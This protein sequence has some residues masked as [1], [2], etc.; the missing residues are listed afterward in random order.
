M[1]TAGGPHARAASQVPDAR[2]VALLAVVTTYRRPGPLEG[3]LRSLVQ[4]SRTPD[5]I[6][7]MDND[8]AESVRLL[9]DRVAAETGANIVYRPLVENLGP[10]GAL[11]RAVAIATAAPPELLVVIDDDDPPPTAFLLEALTSRLDALRRQ[12]QSVA[13]VGLR[14]GT[15]V[16]S[17]GIVKPM[18][19]TSR[20]GVVPVDHLHGGYLPLYVFGALRAVGGPDPSYF[21]G[22][23]ELELGRRLAMSGHRLYCD[24]EAFG[25]VRDLYPKLRA[26]GSVRPVTK[27]TWSVFHKE[28]NLVR[29]LRRERLWSALA[30]TIAVRLF[31]P[32][33]ELFRRR[34]RAS[35]VLWRTRA[36]AAVAGVRGE[37]GRNDRYFPRDTNGLARPRIRSL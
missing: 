7:V 37:G 16:K 9:C 4:Q 36:A 26:G 14:G 10:A 12:D 31:A 1:M 17:T 2:S 29:I 33:A 34:D 15:L 27:A 19:M 24:V 28:R 25:R 6:W 18:P 30:F 8:A 3:T 13:G 20:T 21:F 5:E 23:E 32:P 11:A 35:L 22:F